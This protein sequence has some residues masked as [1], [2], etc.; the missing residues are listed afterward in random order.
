[1]KKFLISA[2]IFCSAFNAYAEDVIGDPPI[3]EPEEEI[4]LE[5]FL[6]MPLT[7]VS[8]MSNAKTPMAGLP[9]NIYYE[10]RK[11][12]EPYNNRGKGILLGLINRVNQESYNFCTKNKDGYTYEPKDI[13]I[14]CD[15]SFQTA[16]TRL[17]ELKLRTKDWEPKYSFRQYKRMTLLELA[18]KLQEGEKTKLFD[19]EDLQED[20][21][22]FLTEEYSGFGYVLANDGIVNVASTCLL[23]KKS[24]VIHRKDL[25]KLCNLTVKEAID[26]FLE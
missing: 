6:K 13:H 1:M 14:T 23:A 19:L 22:H 16:I 2:F 12:A 11:I 4:T 10:L 21:I 5:E 24:G 18:E 26:G 17:N 20:M 9:D 25:K 7:Q 8:Q 15:D 3:D